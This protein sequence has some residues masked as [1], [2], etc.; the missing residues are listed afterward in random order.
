M[1]ST[2]LRIAFSFSLLALCASTAFQVATAQAAPVAPVAAP[3]PASPS[4]SIYDPRITFA[5]L[6]LPDPVNAYRSS[7]GAPGPSYWQNEADYEM[8]ADLDTQA[9][10]LRN[11]ELITYTNNSPDALPSLWIQME[12]NLYRKDSRGQIVNGALMRRMRAATSPG[13]IPPSTEGFELDAVE[14]G[15]GPKTVKADYLIDDTRMQ[16][17]LPVPLAPKGGTLKLHIKYHYTIPGVWG[18]RTSWGMSKQGEI[19]DMAQWYPRMCVYDDLRGWDTLPYIGS[20]FYLEYGHFDYYVTVPSNMIVAGSGE[21]MNPKDVL[22]PTE[23]ERLAQARASDKTVVIRSAAEVNDPSSRPKTS[24]TLTWHFHMDSTRDVVWSASPVFVWDA[25]R[26]NLPDGKTSLAE[27]VYP[28]ESVGAG[29]WSRSTEYVKD[30]VERFSRQWYPYPWPAAINVAGFSTGME[31]PG[32]VFDGIDDKGKVLFWI[33]AHEI[34]HTWFPMIV[35]S[36]ERRNAFMDEGFNTFIDID[37]SAEFQGGVYGPK[38]DSEYSAGGEPSDTILKVLDNP[39]A[40]N[41]LMSADAISWQIG[42]P[43]SYFKGAYGMVLLREQ[44]LGKERFDWAFRKYI[45]DWAFKH[46]S[47]SDFFRELSSEGGEDLSYFWRGWYMNNWRFDLAVT[48]ING[49]QVTIV[50]KGQLVLPATVEVQYTDGTKTRFRLPVEAWESKGE[51]Q[52][53]GDKPIASVTVDPDHV[54]PDDDRS[55]NTLTAK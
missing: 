34:G 52:W 55:N 11:D 4:P 10:I 37:E 26:I 29:A 30:T 41:I 54:L 40:P 38:R 23:M 32:I 42:H 36:N 33:T 35:G 45:R 43:V 46:P 27:S 17:R 6:T 21:L 5:P 50:N 53:A 28:P 2:P 20:E 49:S 7:N 22:T 14:I 39:A 24:G 47:P 48:A 31:Y 1:H 3:S 15:F 9:K 18:G 13:A 12:Q 16:V 25:A 44:I 51:M 8:H 19:Y